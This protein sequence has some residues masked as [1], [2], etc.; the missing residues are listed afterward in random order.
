MR[1]TVPAFVCVAFVTLLSAACGRDPVRPHRLDG[2]A[3]GTTYAVQWWAA[4]ADRPAPPATTVEVVAAAVED[5]LD[6]LDRL[7]STYRPDSTLESFNAARSV[8]PQAVPAE[9]VSLV[10]LAHGVHAASEGCFDATV[11]PLVRAWGFDTDT[12]AVPPDAV[13]DAL[14]GR[15]GMRHVE[16][17]D[18]SHLRKGVAD[19]EVDLS[20]IGQGYTASRLA[21]VLESH[22]IANYLVEIGGEIV[23]RGRRADG[24]AWR[25]GIESPASVE[26]AAPEVLRAVTIPPDGPATAV[27]T[28]GTYRKFF[29]AGERRLSHILDPRTLAPVEHALAAVTVVGPDGAAAAA[30][31][32]A[33]V[34]LGPD[35]AFR[36]AEREHVAALLLI[37]RDGQVEQR[38]TALF[39]EP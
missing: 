5:E 25:V 36:V 3:Q 35:A 27:L 24:A 38:P 21:D 28:S 12:P 10:A 37:E 30:W 11:R 7:L 4:P 23:A 17:V 26:T 19:V 31:A 9:L 1:P 8:A 22:G 18:A 6:R 34:C 2:Y 20:S 13:L 29:T 39:P 14:R 32:T 15:I 16:V 33:L